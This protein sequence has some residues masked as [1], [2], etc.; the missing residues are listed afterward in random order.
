M[1]SLSRNDSKPAGTEVSPTESDGL[2]R[3]SSVP[4]QPMRSTRPGS[5]NQPRPAERCEE[6]DCGRGFECLQMMR[7]GSRRA[8][9]MRLRENDICR[10][11]PDDDRVKPARRSDDRRRP[12]STSESEDEDEIN[13]IND[14]DKKLINLRQR[15]GEGDGRGGRRDEGNKRRQ[16][17]STSVDLRLPDVCVERRCCEGETCFVRRIA[18]GR[19]QLAFCAPVSAY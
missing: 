5:D 3:P 6:L 11:M 12:I 4:S 8:L 16:L 13:D 19:R 10:R 9:C 1:K 14:D 7:N 2:R 18:N 17:T 15:E